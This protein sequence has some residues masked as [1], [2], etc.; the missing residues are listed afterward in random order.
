MAKKALTEVELRAGQAVQRLLRK[1][2]ESAKIVVGVSG[3]ADSI[4]LVLTLKRILGTARLRTVIVD[5]QMQVDSAL[6][7]ARVQK[8]LAGAEIAAKILPV[9][10]QPQGQGLEAAAREARYAALL[11]DLEP[12]EYLA[13]AH[14][15]DDQAETV[16]LGLLR[17]SGPTS[18]AGMAEING[19]ILRPFLELRRQDT[20]EIC[21]LAD[22]PTWKDPQ[23][24][25]L[26]FSRVRIRQQVLPALVELMGA[27][28]PVALARTA[29]LCRMDIAA[30][31]RMAADE[32]A[33]ARTEFS[34]SRLDNPRLEKLTEDPTYP[35]FCPV[36]CQYLAQLPEA[37]SSRV[38]RQWLKDNGL[39]E[40]SFQ[41]SQDLLKLVHNWRGQA[42][43]QIPKA[44]VRRVEK[45]L[46]VVV[47]VGN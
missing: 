43:I 47:Q 45:Y 24:N 26:H 9:D 33:Q 46:Q 2:P 13:V 40:L 44:R 28:L 12:E 22:F 30:L 39:T 14:T 35:E 3:G 23:N 32:L 29:K 4:A 19:R 7:A 5:H 16:L 41:H 1:L 8:L 31:D 6:V 18:L 27:Q 11:G 34:A 36:D 42:E 17:G 20:I 15:L 10:V 38:I 21:T 37:L 25:D